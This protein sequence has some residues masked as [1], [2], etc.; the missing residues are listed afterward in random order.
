MR[1]RG[2]IALRRW[3]EARPGFSGLEAPDLHG[4]YALAAGGAGAI[5]GFGGS[6]VGLRVGEAAR[7]AIM[8]DRCPQGGEL[9]GEAIGGHRGGAFY[10][11]G[12]AGCPAGEKAY[13]RKNGAG[14][15]G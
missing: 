10:A 13:F 4:C 8:V 14:A 1:G 5:D 12:G 6:L 7:D 2:G 9:V 11:W 15:G 3:K